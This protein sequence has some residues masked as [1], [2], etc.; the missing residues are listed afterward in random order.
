MKQQ[1]LIG[2]KRILAILG[3]S[4]VCFYSLFLLI[5]LVTAGTLTQAN[6][7]LYEAQKKFFSSFILWSG[8]VPL[9]GGYA[10]MGLIFISLVSN[11]LLKSQWTFRKIGIHLSH[12]GTLILLAGGFFSAMFSMEGSMTLAEGGKSNVIVDQQNKEFTVT[13]SNTDTTNDIVHVFSAGW[14][15]KNSLIKKEE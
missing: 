10:L 1:L 2:I 11:F 14:L 3:N 9:P 15:V 12:F 13:V 7:G 8:F 6:I 5:C 4:Q